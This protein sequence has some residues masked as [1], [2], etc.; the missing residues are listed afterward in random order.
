MD[1]TLIRALRE[2]RTRLVTQS[3]L[4]QR[5]IGLIDALI[6]THEGTI[7]VVE[8]KLTTQAGKAAGRKRSTGHAPSRAG[9]AEKAVID[10]LRRRGTIHRD[11]IL[12][13][14]KTLGLAPGRDGQMTHLASFLS[15]RRALFVSDKRGSFSLTEAAL[16]QNRPA[17]P[18][19]QDQPD[20]AFGA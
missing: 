14:L 5:Q 12:T 2:E 8:M 3:D 9:L 4:L 17:D 18:P 6:V 13:H 15:T 20:L 16:Q 19:S 1:D 7:N 10:L 11:E